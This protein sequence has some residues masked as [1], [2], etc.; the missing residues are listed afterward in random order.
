VVV[1]LHEEA[2]VLRHGGDGVTSQHW[3]LVALIIF[4][5]LLH[6]QIGL[7]AFR[8]RK[9]AWDEVLKPV[10]AAR[11]IRTEQEHVLYVQAC[12]KHGYI[13]LRNTF[14]WSHIFTVWIIDKFCDTEREWVLFNCYLGGAFWI[15]LLFLWALLAR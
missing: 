6:Y 13:R 1:P 14:E 5:E 11:E 15:G 4:W 12:R 10:F 9:A 3:I 7:R 8:A 2:G